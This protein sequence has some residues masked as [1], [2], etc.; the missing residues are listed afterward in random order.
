MRFYNSTIRRPTKGF[1]LVELLVAVS[2]F[3]IGMLG[4]AGLQVSSMRSNQVATMRWQASVL[5]Y[6]MADRIRVNPVAG[7]AGDYSGDP[8]DTPPICT[9]ANTVCTPANM[10]DYDKS[11]WL[12]EIGA[13]PGGVGTITDNG[14]GSFTVTVR[15]DDRRN[16]ATGTNC[17]PLSD[18]DL[19]CLAV[20]VAL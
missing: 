3:A 18:T 17:P 16:G 20:D 4:L 5:A 19:R 6:N 2:I 15:W 10:A 11:I 9:G 1:T 14:G 13:L 8:S 12:T 7:L